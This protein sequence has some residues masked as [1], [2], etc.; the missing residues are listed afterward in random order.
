MLMFSVD[1]TKRI[2]L[3]K[4]FII[5]TLIL[6]LLLALPT[7]QSEAQSDAENILCVRQNVSVNILNSNRGRARLAN[8]FRTVP[9][10]EGCPR[11]FRPIVDLDSMPNTNANPIFESPGTNLFPD[12]TI[13]RAPAP[14]REQPGTRPIDRLE[15]G[16]V[17]PGQVLVPDFG[18]CYTIET[19][20]V[21]PPEVPLPATLAITLQCNDI[22]NEVLTS[23]SFA[24]PQETLPLQSGL[25]MITRDMALLL[26]NRPVGVELTSVHRQ[27]PGDPVVGTT[28]RL[29]AAI[30]CCPL[31]R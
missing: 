26:D 25:T 21:S 29:D 19:F 20:D 22:E 12:G 16:P 31:L 18:A 1:F 3:M 8:A 23:R 5:P 6:I 10:S 14:L 2:N 15:P 30:T 7:R 11:R 28:H 24:T 9:A 4:N 27:L 17:E 13:R